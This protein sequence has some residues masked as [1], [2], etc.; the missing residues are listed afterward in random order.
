MFAMSPSPKAPPPPP[1]PPPPKRAGSGGRPPAPEGSPNRS[2]VRLPR[3]AVLLL[4]AMLIAL[5]AFPLLS[6]SDSSSQIT[7]Q[8]LRQEV[9]AGNVA[10]IVYDN[11]TGHIDGDYENEDRGSFQT[12]GPVPLSDADR[13]LFDANTTLSFSTPQAGLADVLIQVGLQILLPLLLIGGLIIWWSRRAQGQMGG[14]MSIGRSRAKTY[15]TERPGTTFADVAGYAGVKQEVT[16]VIDFLKTPQKFGEI[17]ARIPKGILLVGPPGTGKTL[18]ARAVAGEAGVPF[19][20]VSGSDFMEMF[21]GVGASRVRD[22]FESARKHGRAIIFVDEI[23]SIGRKRGAGL[24]GGHDEREQTLN[25]ML[26]EMDGFEPSEGIVMMAAT[27]RPDV[28]DPALLRPGRFDR[29]VVV[30]LPGLEDRREILDVHVKHKRIADDVDLDVVA[31][32]TPGMSGA[33]LANLVNEAALFAVRSGA[34]SIHRQHFE[35]ARDRILLGQKRDTLALSDEEK[36][37]IAYHEGGHAVCAALLPHADPVHKVTIIPSG[38][39]LGVTHQL[40]A[41]ERH[42]LRQNYLEDSIVVA[43]GGRV[44]EEIVYGIASTGASNDLMVATERARRMVREWGM[45]ERIGPMAWGSQGQVFLGED[46][47]Q[48]RDYSDDTARVIDEEVERILREQET[49]CRALLEENR[50]GLDLV[51]KALLE[52]ETIDGAEVTRLIAVGAGQI[53][54]E[55]PSYSAESRDVVARA[56]E[57][58]VGDDHRQDDQHDR[59]EDEDDLTPAAA[60]TPID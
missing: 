4:A 41:S 50:A 37:S 40:P 34:D 57:R 46:L 48:T 22:L 54:D 58:S 35:A 16:E 60:P 53:A 13:E 21:V 8:E 17:G 14:I 1:P 39:A 7:F 25:Q 27:N 6:P 9:E 47:M 3:W 49:R 29:Q 15:S 43:M 38:M 10:K 24:G 28:L 52:F 42:L 56:N 59:G 45:S 33:D 32:G 55:G 30:P 31:R 18:I 12:T 19:L 44:A 2:D 36:E 5:V 11:N 23:D 26:A 51:A 20:S